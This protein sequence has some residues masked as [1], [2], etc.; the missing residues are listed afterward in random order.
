MFKRAILLQLCR[1]AVSNTC[2]VASVP[3][4]AAPSANPCTVAQTMAVWRGRG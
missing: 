4:A 2:H 1:Q 3:A